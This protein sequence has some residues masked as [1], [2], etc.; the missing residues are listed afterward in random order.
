MDKGK[1]RVKIAVT[2]V[3]LFGNNTKTIVA[4]AVGGTTEL[5]DDK[6]LRKLA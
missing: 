5:M 2:V 3:D 1:K 4:V 6:K